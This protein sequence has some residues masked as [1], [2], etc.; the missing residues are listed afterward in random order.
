MCEICPIHRLAVPYTFDSMDFFADNIEAFG[1]DYYKRRTL[2]FTVGINDPLY[3]QCFV[4]GGEPQAK[5]QK[6]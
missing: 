5:R 4:D 6:Q 3:K 1:S 2:H